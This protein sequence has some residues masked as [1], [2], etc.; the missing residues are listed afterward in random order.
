MSTIIK[1]NVSSYWKNADIYS[2][3]GQDQ[4]RTYT[5][6]VIKVR[7][8]FNAQGEERRFTVILKLMLNGE[9]KSYSC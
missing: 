7:K 8:I 2:K 5:A 9:S 3:K 4:D 1:N 6:K